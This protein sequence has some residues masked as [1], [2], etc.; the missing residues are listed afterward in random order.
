[1]SRKRFTTDQIIH[2]L[3]GERKRTL[4]E[5]RTFRSIAG[6]P[7]CPGRWRGDPSYPLNDRPVQQTQHDYLGHLKS[8]VL[9]MPDYFRPRS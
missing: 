7:S 1:M 4:L 2:K 6:G 9:A 5:P 8:Q 3:D